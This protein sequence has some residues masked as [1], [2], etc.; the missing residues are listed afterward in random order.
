MPLLLIKIKSYYLYKY[1]GCRIV[2]ILVPSL[3]VL[4]DSINN[5]HLYIDLKNRNDVG[6]SIGMDY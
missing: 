6:Y 4:L 1:Y 3:V 2:V 5:L